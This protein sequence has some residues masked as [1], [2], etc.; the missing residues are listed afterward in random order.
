MFR[1]LFRLIL[2]ILTGIKMAFIEMKAHKMRSILSMLGVLLGTASLTAMLTLIGGIDTFLT[3]KMSRWI[4]S[5]WFME[6]RDP[7]DSTRISFARSPGLRL[8]DGNYLEENSKYV[9][10]VPASIIRD[11]AIAFANGYDRG[12]VRGVDKS[13][14][15]LDTEEI[16]IRYGRNLTNEEYVSG[17]KSCLISWQFAERAVRRLKTD[18]TAGLIGR[19][20]T[21]RNIQ[22]SIVGIYFPK[23]EK[24]PPWHLRRGMVIPIKT[25]QKY[26]TGH[27]PNPGNL[28]VEVVDPRYVKEQA[29]AIS[30]LMKSK[31]RGVE[32][33]EYRTAE[34]LDQVKGMLKNVSLLMAIISIMSLSVGGLSI[35]NVMLSSIAERIREIGIRKALGAK[36]VQIFVQ[37]VAETV[38]LSC[39]GGLCGMIFGLIPLMFKEQIMASTDGAIEPTI[40]PIHALYTLCII[41]GIGVL[42]GL[43]P[44]IKAMKMNPIDAL[45]YE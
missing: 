36:N 33:F 29:Q 42:F 41:A 5:V 32:D 2:A 30:V 13:A 35:M 37:F 11:G 44:A 22:F 18:D 10:N 23:Q 45:R 20:V 27:D 38:T 3:K 4:G 1:K 25:M 28:Q 7:P 26:I 9:K 14:W 16:S 24:D 8:S 31:H 19:K 12:M 15:E 17:V 40:L 34:R 39:I 21:F 6:L 43:Y